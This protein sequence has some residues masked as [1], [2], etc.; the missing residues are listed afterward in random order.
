MESRFVTFIIIYKYVFKG[1]MV[2]HF[3]CAQKSLV[4]FSTLC[5]CHIFTLLLSDKK[6]GFSILL[7][8]FLFLCGDKSTNIFSKC[9]LI[10]FCAVKLSL[11]FCLRLKASWYESTDH[12]YIA[13]FFGFFSFTDALI[14][15][16]TSK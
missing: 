5:N 7:D 10:R 15:F 9:A 1:I 11:I 13:A 8:I 16:L 4:I 14:L 3:A 12:Y 6:G 2:L